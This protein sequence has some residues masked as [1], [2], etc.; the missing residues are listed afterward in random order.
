MYQ[1]PKEWK[2]EKSIDPNYDIPDFVLSIRCATRQMAVNYANSLLRNEEKAKLWDEFC[3]S[4]NKDWI[5]KQII[6]VSKLEQENKK[7]AKL[8]NDRM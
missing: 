7:L 6:L 1:L 3:K 4:G 5:N 2:L 8:L